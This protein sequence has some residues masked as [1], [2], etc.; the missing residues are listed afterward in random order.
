MIQPRKWW[1]FALVCAA[2]SAAFFTTSCTHSAK[3]PT[4]VRAPDA[5]QVDNKYGNRGSPAE[6]DS[7]APKDSKWFELYGATPN[8]R[9]IGIAAIGG[10]AM[11]DEKFRWQMGPMWYR[12]RLTPQSVKAFVVGQEG[13]QDENVSN[14]AFTGSTGTRVQK[15]LN[16]MGI[17]RSYLFMN[18]FVYT[19]NG[20]LQDDPNFKWLEQGQ[21]SPIVEYRHKLF[22]YMLETNNDTIALF[23]GIGSGGKASLATWINSRGGNCSAAY[24][25][26]KCETAGMIKW[27]KDNRGIEIKNKIVAV[28]V[29]HPGGANPN[30]GGAD[31]LANIIQGFEG[32]A[33][34]VADE[35]ANDPTWLPKDEDE[36]LK[37]EAELIARMQSKFKYGH[38]SIPFR[39]FAFNTNWR[40]GQ[41][42]TTSNRWGADSIQVF[43][44]KGVYNDKSSKF[45]KPRDMSTPMNG[46]TGGS[47]GPEGM[48]E[49]ELAYE[50]PRTPDYDY[51]PCGD[52]YYSG[53]IEELC[54]LAT[55]LVTWPNMKDIGIQ[56]ISHE[57]LGYTG[58]YRGRA[59]NAEVFVLADQT[60]HDDLFST[61]ALTG[62]DGQRLNKILELSGVK[63][64]YFILRTFP[65]DV[66]G[67]DV[68]TLKNAAKH[69]LMVA[70]YK[71]I[72]AE[73]SSKVRANI[74]MGPAAIEAAKAM[75]LTN[76]I[77]LDLA[78]L[79]GV[80]EAIKKL[81]LLFNG[82]QT[83]TEYANE[84]TN[85]PRI[86]LPYHTRWWMGTS[87]NRADRGEG[88]ARGDYYRFWAPDWV[89]NLQPRKLT[90]AQEKKLK[91]I[92]KANLNKFY[93]PGQVVKQAIDNSIFE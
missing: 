59:A 83:P 49:N 62:A 65:V 41:E 12:G 26:A 2:L 82:T 67:T 64:N 39:D 50:S 72:Y 35:K 33:R 78:N 21:G 86:D 43:S 29:P 84:L 27:F 18:T 75:G 61:R 31:A 88:P 90:A 4:S 1:V 66:L 93:T 79:E 20:Q 23:M 56:G 68:A 47:I 74:A 70:H 9:S 45:R 16:H 55:L 77:E 57:S 8:Y 7:G 28:G 46:L 30:L 76:V 25:M 17:Y 38:G 71:K 52:K 91:E 42:G 15:F 44:D 32:A 6:Y 5:I 37:T 10:Q 63:S 58:T 81:A 51:G 54:N 22:D 60:S 19:I 48:K 14:R 11:Y 40:M 69:E 87:G 53:K 13:A 85:I 3:Q 80:N 73:V 89:E 36:P 92:Q 24:E 34:K